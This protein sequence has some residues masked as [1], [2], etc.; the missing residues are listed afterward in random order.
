MFRIRSVSDRIWIRVPVFKNNESG[1]RVR[2][3]KNLVNQFRLN[4]RLSLCRCIGPSELD[5]T[6]KGWNPGVKTGSGSQ[7]VKIPGS[8]TVY[9]SAL[10]HN[11]L[12]V[13]TVN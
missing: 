6:R 9:L 13:E 7:P 3:Y 11:Y 1:S 4:M 10:L 5:S 12:I 8:E 2:V